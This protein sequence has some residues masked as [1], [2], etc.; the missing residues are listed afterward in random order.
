MR[1]GP[2]QEALW[3]HIGKPPRYAGMVDCRA[4]KLHHH[5]P[6]GPDGAEQS[7]G[8]DLARLIDAVHRYVCKAPK[9]VAQGISGRAGCAQC[10]DFTRHR[11]QRSC[12]CRSRYTQS[13]SQRLCR[14]GPC[15]QCCSDVG[16]ISSHKTIYETILL[17]ITGTILELKVWSKRWLCRLL[18]G[19]THCLLRTCRMPNSCIKPARMICPHSDKSGVNT[20]A[21]VRQCRQGS[22]CTGTQSW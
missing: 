3:L 12:E 1:I 16:C 2:A 22:I 9:A 8:F 19:G 13:R 20:G 14:Y 11:R 21:T 6:V 4:V 5:E 10:N 18:D 15:R 17:T 7:Q